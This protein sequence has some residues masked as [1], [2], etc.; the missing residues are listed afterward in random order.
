M[1]SPFLKTLF[2]WPAIYNIDPAGELGAGL[3]YDLTKRYS[4]FSEWR[5]QIFPDLGPQTAG[6]ADILD[7][8]VR[9]HF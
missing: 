2:C 6:W 1:T 7:L 4:L 8:G 9:I 3:K 5:V